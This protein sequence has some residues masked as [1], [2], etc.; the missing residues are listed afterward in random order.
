MDVVHEPKRAI[1]NA[2]CYGKGQGILVD[3]I[4]KNP[5]LG[6]SKSKIARKKK[7]AKKLL[8]NSSKKRE[9]EAGVY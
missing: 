2:R 5:K 4:E 9:K 7:A 8:K 1:G 3:K 6:K